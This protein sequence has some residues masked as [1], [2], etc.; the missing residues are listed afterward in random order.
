MKICCFGDTHW[1]EYSSIL[2]SMGEKYSTRLENLIKSV[3]WVFNTA[4]EK[5]CDELSA[6]QMTEA[7]YTAFGPDPLAAYYNAV[8]TETK[9]VRVILS[10]KLNG[11]SAE[12]IRARV[13]EVY[14]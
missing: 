11:F 12:T 14:A 5:K 6:Q 1:S 9:N 3:N 13:R 2:R 10:A 4:L 8:E 7:K